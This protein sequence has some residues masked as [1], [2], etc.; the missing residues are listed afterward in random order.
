MQ[1]IEDAVFEVY[2]IEPVILPA[3]K[4]FLSYVC[5]ECSLTPPLPGDHPHTHTYTLTRHSISY[6]AQCRLK[7]IRVECLPGK[8]TILC[9]VKPFYMASRPSEFLYMYNYTYIIWTRMS[10]H[11]WV[12][13]NEWTRTG[14]HERL[15]TNEWTRTS[16]HK[17]LNTN[18]WTRTSEHERA[19]TIE[20]ARR[21]E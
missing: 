18:G 3:Y 7:T 8:K 14:E 11:D 1:L 9:I 21:R 2:D 10:K 19:N 4:M 15:N 17:R 16:E 12:K 5:T 20:W 6:I 13:M